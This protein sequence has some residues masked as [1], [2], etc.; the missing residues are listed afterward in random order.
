LEQSSR[1]Q[2]KR[3]KEEWGLL[4]QD[5]E[6]QQKSVNTSKKIGERGKGPDVKTPDTLVHSSSLE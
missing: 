5:A 3:T 4:S 2:G 6:M 1:K